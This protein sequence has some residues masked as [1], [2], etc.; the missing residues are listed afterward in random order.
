MSASTR[1]IAAAR[2]TCASRS[3]APR[4][5][6]LSV[7]TTRTP[8]LAPSAIRNPAAA[9]A[10]TKFVDCHAAWTTA[11]AAGRSRP[12]LAARCRLRDVMAL[13]VREADVL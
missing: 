3:S 11:R 5:S 8:C 12:N 13:R 2:E 7:V 9:S 10:S 6:R 1:A 4:N